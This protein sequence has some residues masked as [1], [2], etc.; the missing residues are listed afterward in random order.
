MKNLTKI[1]LGILTSIGGYLEVGSMGTAIQ[2]GAAF[3]YELL[4]AIAL[5][6]ICIAFLVEM[7]GRLAA[8]SRHSVV[9]A[10]RKRFGFRFQVW[11]LLSQVLVD[12]LVLAS[13]IGGASLC[14]AW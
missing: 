12:L 6:T 9:A 14:S 11:P 4:W 13:E 1:G 2:A 7:T 5:G 3:R 8:V 10:V